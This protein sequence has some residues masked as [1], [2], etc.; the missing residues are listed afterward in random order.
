MG[1]VNMQDLDKYKGSGSGAF[2]SL[3]NNKDVARVRFMIT[4]T[5]DLNDYIYA[6][7]QVKV[8]GSEYGRDVSCLREYDDPVDDCPFCAAGM[9]ISVK[10]FLPLYD[11][12]A[13]TVKIWGRGKNFI[14]KMTS[15]CTRYKNLVSHTFEI[16]RNGEKGDQRTTYETYEV[17]KD[18]TELEDLPEVPEIL[19]DKFL[20]DKSAEEMELYLETGSFAP[21][22]DEDV[23]RRRSKSKRAEEDDEDDPPFEEEE[24]PRRRQQADREDRGRRTPARRRPSKEDKF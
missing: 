9:P 16:E 2:F 1:K 22:D 8:P 17:D 14:S 10:L 5:E 21:D 19:G 11:V 12:D 3:K 13:D 4:D 6:V 23:P 24:K 15:L 7:H 20:L 18:D